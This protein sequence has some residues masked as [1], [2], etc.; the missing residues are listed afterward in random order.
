MR[1]RILL[2]LLIFTSLT[3][4]VENAFA[5]GSSLIPFY[6]LPFTETVMIFQGPKCEPSHLGTEA[7]DFGLIDGT[8]VYAAMGGNLISGW[9]SSVWSGYSLGNYVKI[10]D[11]HGD[12]AIYAHLS[13]IVIDT[14][15]VS[16]GTLIGYSGNSTAGEKEIGFHLHFEVRGPENQLINIR[17][18]NGIVWTDPD[19]PCL[20]GQIDGMAYGPPLNLPREMENRRPNMR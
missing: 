18:L 16:Q 6:R 1:L 13:K 11:N 8:P 7:I 15:Y 2:S 5:S 12:T 3:T 10:T 9:D 19:Q 17:S 4:N 20:P 14:G